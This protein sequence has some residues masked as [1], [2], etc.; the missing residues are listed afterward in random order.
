MEP[1][2]LP[3]GVVSVVDPMNRVLDGCA[4]WRHLANIDERLCT[5]AMIGSATR[6]DGDEA[7]SQITLGNLVDYYVLIIT[8]MTKMPN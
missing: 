7:C 1:I 5:A 4:Q 2:E 3:F 6:G 8:T